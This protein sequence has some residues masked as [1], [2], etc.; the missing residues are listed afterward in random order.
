MYSVPRGYFVGWMQRI[1][2]LLFHY[3]NYLNFDCDF[4]LI[5][6]CVVQIYVQV[7]KNIEIHK[8]GHIKCSHTTVV[9]S[10]KMWVLLYVCPGEDGEG[11]A[12]GAVGGRMSA[13][14]QRRV[15]S[16]WRPFCL[17]RHSGHLHLPGTISLCSCI[18]SSCYYVS[19]LL[20][21]VSPRSKIPD[22][23]EVCLFFLRLSLGGSLWMFWFSHHL[24]QD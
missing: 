8:A 11:E 3:Y 23:R 12:G 10:F 13:M 4:D 19:F 5:V 24:L 2:S 1:Q 14:E 21:A 15:C 20:V 16:Q 18:F 17:L 22:W 6:W 7:Y 9:D